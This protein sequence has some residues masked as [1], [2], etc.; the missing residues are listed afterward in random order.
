M[1][2]NNFYY[3]NIFRWVILFQSITAQNDLLA[4]A[5]ISAA[6]LFLIIFFRKKQN[7]Y[8]IL[9]TLSFSLALGTKQY[10]LFALP[11]YLLL[12]VI[13]VIQ[14]KGY[15][16]RTITTWMSSI[17]IFIL[18]VG[19]YT[20]IQNFL[21]FGSFF[22]E[23]EVLIFESSSDALNNFL[24]KVSTNSARLF[25]QF[26]SCEGFPEGLDQKCIDSKTAILNPLFVNQ[27]VNIENNIYLLEEDNPFKLSN[28]Y[29]MN[30]ESAWYGFLSWVL[31]LPA[32]IYGVVYSLKRKNKVG[33]IL[34]LTS[35][36]FF[37]FTSSF[38]FG[39][40]PYVGRYL[41]T[42]VVLIMP[43][44]AF[45]FSQKRVINKL[46]LAMLSLHMQLRIMIH[47]L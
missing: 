38:K 10:A 29:P 28:N 22:G 47:V 20:Y 5:Y 45:I 46:I 43:F 39:W 44:T 8:I 23:K 25:S 11:G 6:F 16:R 15:Q 32:L 40:D 3:L 19:S 2:K 41:I 17:F 4:A 12:F 1:I 36:L 9:S 42:V 26:I 18:F 21:Y 13:C 35:I 14:S 34:I 30:E 33:L 7:V 37:L 31:L 24:P 27:R